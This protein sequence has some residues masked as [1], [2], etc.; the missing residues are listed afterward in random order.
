MSKTRSGSISRNSKITDFTTSTDT[1]SSAMPPKPTKESEVSMSEL[2]EL[3]LNMQKTMDVHFSDLSANITKLTERVEKNEEKTDKNETAIKDINKEICEMAVALNDLTTADMVNSM[4]EILSR[5]SYLE[6]A[7]AE[8]AMYSRKNN[9]MVHGIPGNESDNELTEIKIRDFAKNEL[10][11]ESFDSVV[12]ANCH[13]LPKK[14]TSWG[15]TDSSDPIVIKFI[16][17]QDREAF[18]R[19]AKNLGRNSTKRIRTHLPPDMAKARAKLSTVAYNKRLEGI[20]ARIREKGASI[21]MDLRADSSSRWQTV[22]TISVVNIVE[23]RLKKTP[24]Q[25]N[26]D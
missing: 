3:M 16:R 1:T 25:Y 22:E 10:K 9:L 14:S 12:L 4:D 13:R 26:K 24:Y 7:E 5:L 18:L 8:G 19:A 21:V 20:H 11:L 23:N 6:K 15:K 17:W 2:K